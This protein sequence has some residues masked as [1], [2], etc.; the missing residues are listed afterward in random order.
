MVPRRDWFTIQPPSQIHGF[1]HSARVM[2]W[3][4]VLAGAGPLFEPALWAAACHDLCRL[5][6][7]IDPEHGVRAAEW[8]L[9]E[10]PRR[11]EEPPAELD[12]IARACQWHAHA[13]AEVGWR[14]ELLWLLKDAD[15]LDRVRFGDLD[16]RML[17][18][19]EA[20]ALVGSAEKLFQRTRKLHEP[21]DIW[22]EA[23]RMG[24][25]IDRLL[26]FDFGLRFEETSSQ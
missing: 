6:D 8:V 26:D 16:V 12:S 9:T 24:L 10:L 25:P 11:L 2:V 17:H 22:A 7:G 5:D 19:D 1:A 14:S 3:T 21:V 20:R 4:T 13:A 23:F 15:G 18:T